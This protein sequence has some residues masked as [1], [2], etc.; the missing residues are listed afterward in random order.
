MATITFSPFIQ[1]HISC[2]AGE[3]F[4]Q[5]VQEVL[6]AYFD[7][8]PWIRGCILDNKGL[9][10]PRLLLSVD[11]VIVT[12]RTGL[13]E[14]VHVRAKLH[15]REVLLDAEYEDRLEGQKIPMRGH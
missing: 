8:Y 14:P 1:Q 5:T 4:G 7:K 9:L 15:I 11:G 2:P 10:R 12:D 3:A 13:S 6:D